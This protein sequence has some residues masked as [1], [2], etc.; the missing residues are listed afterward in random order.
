C[1]CLSFSLVSS[2]LSFL[3]SLSIKLSS[4]WEAW[5]CLDTEEIW[6]FAW[7]DLSLTV[8][9]LVTWPLGVK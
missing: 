2:N 5:E 1:C 7:R 8:W 4:G 6:E 3:S 9:T